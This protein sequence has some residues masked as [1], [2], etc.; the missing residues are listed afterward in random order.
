MTLIY[1]H[2][3]GS[4]LGYEAP[5]LRHFE[6]GLGV[7][8][9]GYDY[10]GYGL[11]TGTAS[12][13]SIYQDIR[14]VYDALRRGGVFFDH[15]LR[16][17]EI[18]LYGQSLGTCASLYLAAQEEDLGGIILESPLLSVTHTPVACGCCYS[19]DRELRSNL[20]HQ[21]DVGEHVKCPVLIMHGTKDCL[22]P[23]KHGRVLAERLPNVHSTLWVESAGHH[24]VRECAGDVQYFGAMQRFVVDAL[25]HSRT[26]SRK[27]ARARARARAAAAAPSS[28]SPA[29]VGI[30][31]EVQPTE[32][33]LEEEP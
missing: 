23:F 31:I 30:E 1:S 18:I 8:V 20:F 5:Y 32:P 27:R 13:E 28:V 19:I 11:S 6:R 3:S 12:E 24:N 15:P 26:V 21:I 25:S 33:E 29:D 22:V 7:H 9:V 10:S 14:C 2:G 4:D 16:A 17:D